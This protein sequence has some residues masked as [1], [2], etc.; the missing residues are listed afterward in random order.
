MVVQRRGP[1]DSNG[2]EPC[3]KGTATMKLTTITNV[4]VDGVMQ[5]LGGSDE[6]RRGGFERGG[7]ALPLFDDEAATFLNQVYGRAD[8]FLFAG[9]PTRSSPAT[10]EQCQIRT[11]TPPMS[12]LRVGRGRCVL[13]APGGP[14]DLDRCP[15]GVA[16][17]STRSRAVSGPRSARVAHGSRAPTRRTRESLK[18][19]P[20]VVSDRDRGVRSRGEQPPTKG[21]PHHRR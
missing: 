2:E 7:W 12:Q 6:D 21:A 3:E 5:G 13:R 8:A 9:G 20:E 16:R 15:L 1:V 4:S 19:F 10:G 14:V 11:T 18:E 17:E